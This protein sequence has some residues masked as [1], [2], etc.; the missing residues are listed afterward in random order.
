[1][2]T[3]CF[4][5]RSPKASLNAVPAV[6]ITLGTSFPGVP[7]GNDPWFLVVGY[8]KI[9]SVVGTLW[10]FSLMH[11]DELVLNEEG[12]LARHCQRAGL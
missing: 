6:K 3:G 4:L 8:V 12:K 7:A 2:Q 1:M 11:R 10:R 9:T 5:Y